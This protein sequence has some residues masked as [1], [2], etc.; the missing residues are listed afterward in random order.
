MLIEIVRGEKLPVEFSLVNEE[1]ESITNVDD[2]TITCRKLPYEDSP[3]LFQKKFSDVILENN[4]YIF[5]ILEEDTKDL[6][7]G[8]YGY[9]IKITDGDLIQKFVGEIIIKE[10][11]NNEYN[12][13]A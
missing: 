6:N 4:K 7:Y 11:Y 3:I 2:I 10:E 12:T 9:D 8:S 5:T 13:E 1:G